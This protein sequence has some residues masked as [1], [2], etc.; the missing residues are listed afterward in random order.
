MPNLVTLNMYSICLTH[1]FLMHPFST[2]R[3]HQTILRFPDVYRGQ[4]KGVV[5]T[6]GLKKRSLLDFYKHLLIRCVFR[7]QLNIY[8]E[9]F[10]VMEPSRGGSNVYVIVILL[11][12]VNFLI[13]KITRSYNKITLLVGLKDVF[14]FQQEFF[15]LKEIMNLSD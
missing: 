7:T 14:P 4:R 12:R 5:G 10:L 13:R 6:N 1:L 8:D 2:P 3:K 15:Q 9:G 11:L